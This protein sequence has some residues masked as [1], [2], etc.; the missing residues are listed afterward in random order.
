MEALKVL[1][2]SG[3]LNGPRTELGRE[4]FDSIKELPLLTELEL[5]ACDFDSADAKPLGQ[6]ISLKRLSIKDRPVDD[7]LVEVLKT[8]GPMTYAN[9]WGGGI[10]NDQYDSLEKSK[11]RLVVVR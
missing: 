4:F 7:E 9:L 8:I 11:P 6:M 2:V 5:E 3:A 10:S 1:R